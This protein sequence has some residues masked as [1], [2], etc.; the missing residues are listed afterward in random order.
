MSKALYLPPQPTRLVL[1]DLERRGLVTLTETG[2]FLY[3]SGE[4]DSLI[5]ALDRTYRHQV[6]RISNMIHA[7]PS[8]SLREFARAF[9][10]K[11]D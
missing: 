5:E 2:S 9:R 10:L 1:A 8:A 4:R 3:R 6:V 7:K 11:K